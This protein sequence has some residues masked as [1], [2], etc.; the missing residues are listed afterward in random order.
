MNDRNNNAGSRQLKIEHYPSNIE[1]EDYPEMSASVCETPGNNS[2]APS[3]SKHSSTTFQGMN[4]F[5]PIKGSDNEL[6]D[7]KETGIDVH[8]NNSR[9][10]ENETINESKTIGEEKSIMRCSDVL[11]VKLE[12]EDLLTQSNSQLDPRLK[13]RIYLFQFIYRLYSALKVLTMAYFSFS[14]FYK[15]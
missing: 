3:T 13:T 1:E 11:R 12:N 2:P 5:A 6:E 4:T 7:K 15:I 10:N 8:E 14:L 9:A